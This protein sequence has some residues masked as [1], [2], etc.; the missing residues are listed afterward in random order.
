MPTTKTWTWRHIKLHDLNLDVR[1]SISP[2]VLHGPCWYL[3]YWQTKYTSC[4]RGEFLAGIQPSTV[5]LRIWEIVHS[6]ASLLQG[7]AE[8]SSSRSNLRYVKY[9]MFRISTPLCAT[10]SEILQPHLS[11]KINGPWLSTCRTCS[12]TPREG[13]N[14]VAISPL[15]LVSHIWGFKPFSLQSLKIL[16]CLWIILM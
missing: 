7:I 15:M 3:T 5:V 8:S 16:Q 2:N 10:P 12:R 6:Y 14:T 11:C 13:C 4:W 9:N 1:S